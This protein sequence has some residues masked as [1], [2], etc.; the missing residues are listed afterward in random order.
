ME[1]V[2][3]LSKIMHRLL[4]ISG[5]F[6]STGPLLDLN[7]FFLHRINRK[8]SLISKLNRKKETVFIPN[9]VRDHTDVLKFTE[10]I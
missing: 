3:F 4:R 7:K 9:K 2:I 5:R 1:S 6:Q 8:F 10:T